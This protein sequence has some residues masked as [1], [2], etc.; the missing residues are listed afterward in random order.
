[1][2]KPWIVPVVLAA[3][4]LGGCTDP[5]SGPEARPAPA[6]HS[7]GPSATTRQPAPA[8][9]APPAAPPTVL[10]LGDSLATENQQVLGDELREQ[11][12]ADYTGAPYSGTTVCDYLEG[13]AGRSL[14]P[15]SDKA[16]A[17]VREL[18]PDYVVLQFWG[19]SW[20]YTP[21]MDGITYDG[22]PE[23][24]FARYAADVRR[25]TDQIRSAGGRNGPRIVWVL[26]GPDPVT[27]ERVR[28]VNALYERRAAGSGD[29]VA[30][31]GAAVSPAGA[32]YTW[33]QYLPC[34]AYER[35]RPGHC[36]EPGR[37][38]TALHLDEDP[39]HFC[40]APTTSEPRPCPVPSPG[41]RRIAREITRVIA[42]HVR[43]G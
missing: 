28:R 14:V 3:A 27:P 4:L 13:S 18:R 10:Y 2:R 22:A 21:C 11:L 34:D 36:T 42:G 23:R 9:P 33:A 17:L 5:S 15:A 39:L 26:Q 25:L 30:D 38:R 24:Y 8:A 1:M 40:L 29:L 20:G 31:A 43:A 37:D 41:I 19:N 32:R 16:A 6:A 35:A 12:R 7:P